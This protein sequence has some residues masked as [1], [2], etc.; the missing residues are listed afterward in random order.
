M[1]DQSTGNGS[2]GEHGEIH[3]PPNSW[4]PLSTSLA[5]MVFLVGLLPPLGPWVGILGAVWLLASCVA[6]FR[7]AR[8]EYLDLP[9]AGG[10]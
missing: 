5:L 6:W 1:S 10:H 9:E 8:S 3:L 2:H 4:I 7:S